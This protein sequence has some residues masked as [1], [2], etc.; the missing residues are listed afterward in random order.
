MIRMGVGQGC[1]DLQ[2]ATGREVVIE[3]RFLDKGAYPRQK[4][5]SVMFKRSVK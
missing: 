3:A 1:E 4:V 2:V 5:F